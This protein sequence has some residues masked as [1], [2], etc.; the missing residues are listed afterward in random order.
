MTAKRAIW[1]AG[2]T[3]ATN[4]HQRTAKFRTRGLSLIK[5]REIEIV[6]LSYRQPHVCSGKTGHAKLGDVVSAA[7]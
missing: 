2:A 3:A 4:K 1:L 7:W 5:H 6:C